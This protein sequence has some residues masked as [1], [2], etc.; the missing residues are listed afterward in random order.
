[1]NDFCRVI[2]IEEEELGDIGDIETLAGYLLKLKGDFPTLKE[3]L[4]SGSLHFH[5]MKMEK[6]RILQVSLRIINQKEQHINGD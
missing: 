5:V 1:M 4:I 2:N 6:H 3:T